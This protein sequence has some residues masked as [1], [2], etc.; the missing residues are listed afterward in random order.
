MWEKLRI[1]QET[2]VAHPKKTENTNGFC[3]SCAAGNHA[4][5]LGTFLDLARRLIYCRCEL[6]IKRLPAFFRLT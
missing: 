2:H 3:P 6:C 4:K 5:H 1:G